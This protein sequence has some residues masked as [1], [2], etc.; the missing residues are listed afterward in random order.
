[1]NHK[2]DNKYLSI[3]IFDIE[4]FGII[5]CCFGRKRKKKRKNEIKKRRR[6]R[7]SDTEEIDIS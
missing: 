7:G 4:M 5:I 3:S 1:M 6:G 2:K